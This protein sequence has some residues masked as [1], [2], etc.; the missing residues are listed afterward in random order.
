MNFLEQFKQSVKANRM[1]SLELTP[2]FLIPNLYEYTPGTRLVGTSTLLPLYLKAGGSIHAD[3]P[4]SFT[5]YPL[6]S[7]LLLYTNTGG[8]RLSFGGHTLSVTEGQLLFLDCSQQFSLSSL[9]LPWNFKLF[10]IGGTDLHLFLPLLHHVPSPCFRIPTFSSV[11]RC[12]SRLLSL[13]TS[14]SLTEQ[15]QMHQTLTELLTEL[16]LGISEP[17][18]PAAPAAAGYLMEMWDYF[19]RH[20]DQPFSLEE[21]EKQFQVSRYRLCREFSAA[22][23]I[24]PQKYLT[25]KR[26]DEAKK[27][28]LTTDWTI[29]E[30]SSKVGYENTTHFIHLFKKYIGVTPGDF[31]QTARAERSVS[32]CCVQ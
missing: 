7:S 4:F 10:F 5:F 12:I 14:P 29:Q 31:R 9:V 20:Y 16:C 30:I 21:F 2:E 8:G 19:E 17:L 15:L 26:L 28:L 27:M 1:I 13:H 32:R 11:D 22:Y 23:G 24:P 18:P 6:D 25:H 3:F